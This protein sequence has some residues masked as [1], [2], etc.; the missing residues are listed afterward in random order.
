[1]GVGVGLGLQSIVAN[2]VSGVILIF[3]RPI[4]IGDVI[5]SGA[6]SGRVKE[7]GLRT[8]RM[9]TTSGSE[10]II[11]NANILNQNI[12]NWTAT[13]NY[14]LTE[15]NFTV[16]GTVTRQPVLE[17]IV[18]ALNTVIELDSETEP[19]VF[20]DSI[21]DSKTKVKVK[22]WCN[23]Y[24]TEQAVSEVRLALYESFKKR[25]ICLDDCQ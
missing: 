22:F 3:E 21:S 4:Q 10:V 25:D 16:T 14:K 20:F 15:V 7:I 24:R 9:D 8:T 17:V 5:E 23:I 18:A 1:L 6:H 12:V 19:Q 2:F 11:P 13:D